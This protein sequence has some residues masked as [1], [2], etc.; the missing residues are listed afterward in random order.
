VV[1]A[2][3]LATRFG[4]DKLLHPY[5]G[6]PLAAHI[7]DTLVTMP[8]VHRLAVV[9]PAPSRRAEL[10]SERDFQLVTNPDPGQGMGS[11]L[12]LGAQ[13]ADELGADALLVC[14]ADMPNVTAEHLTKLI[15]ASATSDAVATGFD[16]SRGPPVIFARRLFRDLAA[17]SG[18]HGARH[19]LANT[20]LIMA[21][22]GLARDFDTPSDFEQP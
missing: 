16:A 9:P 1:L 6:K 2:A 7:A 13:R 8:L 18:D 17:L 14:L 10:F 19:L 11:S 20:T 15:A 21:P 3:G 5:A 4:G 22:P 12:A